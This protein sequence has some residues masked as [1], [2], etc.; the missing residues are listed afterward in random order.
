MGSM[1]LGSLMIMHEF[2][3]PAMRLF[4]TML[5]VTEYLIRMLASMQSS[6]LAVMG[7]SNDRRPEFHA[8]CAGIGDNPW[9]TP[10]PRATS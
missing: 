3:K 1:V 8:R 6:C 4:V 2:A 10:I 7:R 5:K 9:M